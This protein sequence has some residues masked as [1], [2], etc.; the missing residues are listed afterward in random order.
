MKIHFIGIGGI[1]MSALAGIA[2]KSGYFISGSDKEKGGITDSLKRLGAKIHI[3]HD[4]KN[5]PL[6][7]ELVVINQAIKKD[8]PELLKA[9]RLGIPVQ[10]RSEY[11]G[12]LMK[13]KKA[14][15]IA[16]THGKTTISSMISVI[17]KNAGLDPT[18]AVG[19]IIPEMENSNWRKGRS[20]FM[21]VEACEYRSSFLKLKPWVTI[22]S[23]IE[24]E[25]LDCFKN[26]E[27]VVNVFS[28][29]LKLTPQD[30][31]AVVNIDDLNIQKILDRNN[32]NFPIITYGTSEGAAEWKIGN[33]KE[34]GGSASP[35]T[36]PNRGENQGGRVSFEV[37]KNT[38]KIND[39][40]IKIPGKHNALNTLASII[41]A[42]KLEIN[43]KTI[44]EALENFE[45]TKRRMEVKGEKKG[46]LV[47]DDYGHHP[48]E[49]KATL[50]AV[51]SFYPR[52]KKLWCVF[53]PHQYSRTRL[54]FNDFVKAFPLADALIIPDIYKVRDT[55]KDIESVSSGMLAEAINKEKTTEAF[56]IPT[57]KKVANF[58]SKKAKSGDL[59]LTMGAGPVY[60]VGELFLKNENRKE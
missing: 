23:N 28:K 46:V 51:K 43:L 59:I 36:S 1:G 10:D 38:Q 12:D 25:H 8:N 18:V 15:A 56:Y 21:V 50:E 44:K 45:G 29:F 14:I 31:F 37:F 57:F 42:S 13:A 26:L 9:K 16:G 17:L 11:L 41:L 5:L 60:K 6:D 47:I 4:Q 7:T 3:G 52:R 55:K 32:F 20:D 58:L 33:I 53:Q 22:I 40:V 34:Q 48:T 54:L 27:E 35:P 49:I 24:E 19:G 30:G 39:F 2:L